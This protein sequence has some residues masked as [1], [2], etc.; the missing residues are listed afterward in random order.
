M[1][2]ANIKYDD[3]ANGPGVRTSLFVSGCTHGCKGCFNEVAWDFKYGKLFSSEIIEEILESLRPDYISGLTILGGEPMEKV[4]QKGIL[5]LISEFK[6]RYPD[7]SLWIYSGYT[8]DSDLR[9][10]GRAYCDETDK[11][12]SF[13]DVIVDGKFVESLYNIKSKNYRCGK[14]FGE[15]KGGTVGGR[16]RLCLSQHVN[17]HVSCEASPII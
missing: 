6:N 1:N 3:I 8:F 16:C 17:S 2:Y 13:C 11:I 10:G 15:K 5:P 14:E 7:K 12:L 4:N 9:P